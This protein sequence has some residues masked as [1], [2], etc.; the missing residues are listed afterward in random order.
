MPVR[1]DDGNWVYTLFCAYCAHFL[2]IVNLLVI[3][4]ISNGKKYDG[5]MFSNEFSNIFIPFLD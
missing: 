4:S 2:L 5:K 1:M 3:K